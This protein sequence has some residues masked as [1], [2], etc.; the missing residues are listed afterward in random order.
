MVHSFFIAEDADG[1]I[2]LRVPQQGEDELLQILKSLGHFFVKA[3]YYAQNV[4]HYEP[5]EARILQKL[6]KA[7]TYYHLKVTLWRFVRGIIPTKVRLQPMINIEETTC[8]LCEMEE[9]IELHLMS[10]T[11]TSS[12]EFHFLC[13]FRF[14][15]SYYF[16]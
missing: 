2:E 10:N 8:P 15:S 11:R 5:K 6:Y 9:E 3:T 14:L 13:S 1:V 16:F 4:Y 7:K 12:S